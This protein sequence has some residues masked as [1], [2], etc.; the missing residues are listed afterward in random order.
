MENN[1]PK[2]IKSID[3]VI[4]SSI[5]KITSPYFTSTGFDDI[6]KITGGLRDGDLIIIGARP[7]MGKTALILS[8]IL[9]IAKSGKPVG[10]FSLESSNVQTTQKLISIFCDLSTVEQLG[11]QQ[12]K[13][14]PDSW[15]TIHAKLNE[16]NKLPIYIDDNSWIKID[17]I[18]K[19][20]EK[21]VKENGV[22]VIVIDYLQRIYSQLQYSEN[23]YLEINYFTRALKSLA[24]DLDIPIVVTSQLNRNFEKQ[25]L[26]RIRP[27]LTDLRD[28]GTICEDADIVSFIHRPEYY[29]ITEDCRGNSLIGI[30][31]FIVAKN[32]D[33]AIGNAILNFKANRFNNLISEEFSTIPEMNFKSQISPFSASEGTPF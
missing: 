24:L 10:F 16:L 26:S 5:K 29:K 12:G 9:N 14:S 23:R 33:G 21:M 22:K 11:L 4:Q 3:E 17:E 25:N 32:R 7:A 8:M 13:L 6:D 15:S 30:A 28:S 31:E 27:E 19:N 18:C 20:A 2:F 1:E